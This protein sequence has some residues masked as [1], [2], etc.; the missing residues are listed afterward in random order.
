[1]RYILEHLLYDSTILEDVR[2]IH[3][4][5]TLLQNH[6]WLELGLYY[7]LEIPLLICKSLGHTGTTPILIALLRLVV[8]LVPV[9]DR[10][11]L[12]S[13][14]GQRNIHRPQPP[15]LFD[16]VFGGKFWREVPT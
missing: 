14:H 13:R 5:A 4:E 11:V 16:L 6:M 10:D 3:V 12:P 7:A 15:Y 2:E 8:K 1:M 9:G